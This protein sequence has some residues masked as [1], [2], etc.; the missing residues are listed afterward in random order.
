MLHFIALGGCALL[1]APWALSK[2]GVGGGSGAQVPFSIV[3]H[4]L[5]AR[6]G[7]WF[8]YTLDVITAPGGTPPQ[9]L[10]LAFAV[11][12]AGPALFLLQKSR[13]LTSAQRA[14]PALFLFAVAGLYVFVP[15]QIAGPITHYWTYPRFGTYLLIALLLLPRPRL[16]GL[17]A[18]WLIPGVLSA[19]FVHRAVQKQFRSYGEYV[20]PYRQIVD[21]LP[22]NQLMLPLDLDDFA[23]NETHEGVLAQIHGYA[24]AAKSCF[25]P[26]LFD[27]TNIPLRYRAA[28]MPPIV[29]WNTP[30]SFSFPQTGS[31][32]D[33][34]II[35]SVRTDPFDT[36]PAWRAKVNLVK[37]AG[38]WRLYAVKH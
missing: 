34:I 16:D 24:A 3:D 32:Y 13:N 20:Q 4:P 18:L 29:N 15:F 9:I 6:L 35:H 26:H 30:S 27:E 1:I 36:H 25:D 28:N 12:L 11:L 23:W 14:A 33:Y 21:A 19:F 38:P 37:Q 10:K 31:A 7:A 5:D 2:F 8:S 17:R 22:R